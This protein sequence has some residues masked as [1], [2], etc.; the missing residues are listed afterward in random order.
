MRYGTKSVRY[1]TKSTLFLALK[2]LQIL[3]NEIKDSET[4]HISKA[5]LKKVGSSRMPL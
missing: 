3:R 1:G 4:L 5:K 2:M